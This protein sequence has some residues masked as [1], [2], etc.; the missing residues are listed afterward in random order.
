VVTLYDRH[1]CYATLFFYICFPT[2]AL[3]VATYRYATSLP[4]P[5][6]T[7]HVY[8]GI[9]SWDKEF[10][11]LEQSLSHATTPLSQTQQA[12][13]ASATHT[14][15]DDDLARTAA[16]LIDAVRHEENPKFKASQFIGLMRQLRD[17]DVT[18]EGNQIVE[19]EPGTI[20]ADAKGKGK[21]REMVD[22]GHGSQP[23]QAATF[24]QDFLSQQAS[25][26]DERTASQLEDENEAFF[27]QENEELMRGFEHEQR[28]LD[29]RLRAGGRTV[30]QTA[31]WDELQRDWDRFEA[32]AVGIRPVAEYAFQANNPYAYG[33]ASRTR[34]HAM[35]SGARQAFLEVCRCSTWWIS[36]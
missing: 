24:A 32:T 19:R 26:L 22:L 17:G 16:L 14:Q 12:Q 4:L 31:P 30:P 21:A 13:S 15:A 25:S 27:R 36:P 1:E 3:L 28:M 23:F 6:Y 10:K 35:H 18:V 29:G 8:P 2:P 7:A 20:T 9:I 34:H 11:T 5:T 33:E